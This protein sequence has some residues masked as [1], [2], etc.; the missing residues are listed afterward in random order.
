[1]KVITRILIFTIQV[2]AFTKFVIIESQENL[3]RWF[4]IIV[5][6]FS[7]PVSLSSSASVNIPSSP[8]E[9][10]ILAFNV[11][12]NASKND[13]S[14]AVIEQANPDLVCLTELTP[15]F[16]KKFETMLNKRYPYR[17]FYP[18]EGTWGVGI[19]S[20]YP[21]SHAQ[22]FE[23]K[24]HR[25]PAMEAIVTF[26]TQKIMVACPHLMA[27][28]G[29][30]KKSDGFFE[31]MKKNAELRWKQAVH[32]AARYAGWKGGIIIAGDMNEEA[33]GKAVKTFKKAGFLLACECTDAKCG[34]TFP[35]A[36][37]LIPAVWEIDHILGR[38]VSFKSARVIH[39]GGSDH[40]PVYATFAIAKKKSM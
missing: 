40:F 11:L 19:A 12:Y 31:T 26:G 17:I 38:G 7:T 6:F 28:L 5:F 35:G 20:R 2:I 29:K 18:M 39:G 10:S 22:R 21:L 13:E 23:E 14:I 3:N 36:T 33:D 4:L 15:G 27:P 34:A 16:V 9:F 8:G 37:S 25:I 32:L 24:P 1:M 30:H